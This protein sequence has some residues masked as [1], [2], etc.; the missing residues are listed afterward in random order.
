[1]GEYLNPKDGNL[2][3]YPLDRRLGGSQSRFGRHG[4]EKI[5]SCRESNPGSQAW[6]YTDIYFYLKETNVGQMK[7]IKG[8]E[9]I[10]ELFCLFPQ[11]RAAEAAA[12]I[13]VGPPRERDTNDLQ[14]AARLRHPAETEL[15]R[16]V[17]HDVVNQ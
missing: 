9:R 12:T 7:A 11:Q 16:W 10:R 6:S 3:P 14:T 1:M 15:R 5:L 13:P 4:E 8:Q 17:L 2:P